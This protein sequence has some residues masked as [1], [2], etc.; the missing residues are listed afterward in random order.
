VPENRKLKVF[1]CHSK[2]DKP[3]V[4]ELYRRLV[5][6]GFDAWLD[7]E[8]LLP[9]QDWRIEIPKAIKVADAVI[10]CLSQNSVSKEGYIQKEIKFALDIADEK[11]EDTIYIIPAKLEECSVPERLSR[12][13]WV[14]L[15][16]ES[17]YTRLLNALDRRASDV[18]TKSIVA[19]RLSIQAFGFGQVYVYGNLVTSSQWQTLSV[20]E[21][22]F[23]FLATTKPM[24]KEMIAE[25]LWSEVTDP[26]KSMMRF[27]NELHRLRQAV[28]KD[29]IIYADGL[30]RFN[31]DSTY[32]YDVETFEGYITNA[33]SADALKDQ[34]NFYQKAIELVKGH[35]FEDTYN[36][37][38]WPE[39]ER[40]SQ[41]FLSASF[42][43]GNL[44]LK[45]GQ[46]PEALSVCQQA[47]EY[48][49][50]Y[51]AIYR[52][53]MQIYDQMGNRA[54]VIRTYRSCEETMQ[55]IFNLP[56]STETMQLYKDLTG[57]A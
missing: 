8:K 49:A 43:L 32:E 57:K 9:G 45:S 52:L 19:P 37:W 1:L 23:F 39:R 21:L 5:A 25:A 26:S 7:E 22:F 34:I 27:A 42:T 50:T 20:R 41:K 51:E 31:R 24:H 33:Q 13:Q 11:P 12:W 14:E 36:T 38:V 2:D 15:F 47:V 44:Y 4:R 28:G 54:S 56:P 53:M 48:E 17:G 30:Y 10:V 16:R 35:F 29:T 46:L 40:L 18:N 3:R 6:N 55:R